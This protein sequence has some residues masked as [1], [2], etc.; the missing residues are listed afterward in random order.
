M[1]C[2][3]CGDTMNYEG[4]FADGEHH[5]CPRCGNFIIIR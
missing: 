3:K 1:S 2:P 4:R 5:R